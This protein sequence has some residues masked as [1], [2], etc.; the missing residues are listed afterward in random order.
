MCTFK[1]HRNYGEIQI[2][3]IENIRTFE[4]LDIVCIF[5]CIGIAK[6]G[7]MVRINK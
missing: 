6:H 7:E 3:I 4:Y 5:K 1:Y 2:V